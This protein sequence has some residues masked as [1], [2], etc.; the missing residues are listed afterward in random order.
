MGRKFEYP[1]LQELR[2]ILNKWE[3][4]N[5]KLTYKELSMIMYAAR[6]CYNS[7]NNASWDN[8][9]PAPYD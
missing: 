6:D 1:T 3:D 8:Y 4:T 7:R 9:T 2:D 5:E